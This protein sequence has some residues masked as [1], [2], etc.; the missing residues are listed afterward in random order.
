MNY[1][2]DKEKDTY[3]FVGEIKKIKKTFKNKKTS[4]PF[5]KLLS[6]GIK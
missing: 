1:K 5:D 4:G 2:K 3:I 6:L